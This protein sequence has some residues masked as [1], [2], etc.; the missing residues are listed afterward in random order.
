MIK[1]VKILDNPNHININKLN[2]IIS[3]DSGLYPNIIGRNKKIKNIDKSV[4]TVISI[5]WYLDK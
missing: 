5:F 1:F 3:F 2:I 4:I